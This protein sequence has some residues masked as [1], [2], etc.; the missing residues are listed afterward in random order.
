MSV[1]TFCHLVALTATSATLS[2]AAPRDADAQA[3]AVAPIALEQGWSE[4]DRKW[5][6][7]IDQGS[8]LIPRAWLEALEQAN[9]TVLFLDDANIRRFGYLPRPA[10]ASGGPALP[11]GFSVDTQIDEGLSVTRLRWREDQG[12]NEAWVGLNCAA[13]HTAEISYRGRRMHVQGGPTMADFQ[14]F[15]EALDSAVRQTRDDPEKRD[16]FS[17]RV[18]GDADT[19]DNRQR[20]ANAIA[21]LAAWQ[22]RIERQNATTL[23]YGPGRLDAVG[24]IMNKVALVVGAPHPEPWPADAPVSY[25]HIWNAPQHDRVQWN[26]IARN[27][28]NP[29]R[30]RGEE[31]D[32]GAL[33]RNAGEVIGVFADV[34]VD[35]FAWN[36]F[37]SSVQV[38][39]LVDIERAL[40]RLKSP[41]WP[42][43][44][45]GPLD[46]GLV[47]K[48]RRL[49]DTKGCASCHD[50]LSRDD[51]S[52]PVKARMSSLTDA[53][54][55][56][57]MACNAWTYTAPSGSLEGVW[58][59]I[60]KGT[61]IG[62]RDS[63]ARL[64]TAVVTGTLIGRAD[65]L[66]GSVAK[67]VFSPR[68]P[69]TAALGR[70]T[71][72]FGPGSGFPDDPRKRAQA[73]GCTRGRDE[74]L[75]YK[76][77]PLNGIWATAP[78]LH[79]GSVPTLYDL[80]LPSSM[81]PLTVAAD[82]SIA[83]GPHRPSE[84]YTGTIEFDPRRVGFSTDPTSPG[85]R[86]PFRTH[87][88]SGI[89]I[90]GNA[91]TGHD[92]GNS[93]L[94]DEERFALIEYLKTL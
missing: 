23:R 74:I 33:G 22:E 41:A 39:N 76:A 38:R 20:L 15:V 65:S 12:R 81:R 40:G 46:A 47:E 16:R 64:L 34:S 25:P 48:G 70:D 57:W 78:Y 45:F 51:L 79:N 60:Y 5:W 24:H 11:V 89:E 56:I 35:G 88:G 26:G 8:R 32:F 72:R 82:A 77:R 50:S 73:L 4:A 44:V 42:V 2:S 7:D 87:D 52:S 75:A 10:P 71:D 66:V 80:L 67:D 9:S 13:C 3:D 29:I 86:F 85:N 90:L 18:L 69:T 37:R 68:G 6:S 91:N 54:T 36:G 53:G 58:E 21:S 17:K 63:G 1:K 93:A 59:R 14:G 94:S 19:P 92:Y 27:D 55:D 83:S 49:F 28:G 31:T 62:P 30:I 61:A 43:E 84:F